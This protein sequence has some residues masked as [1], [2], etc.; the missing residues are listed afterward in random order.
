[1]TDDS[2]EANSLWSPRVASEYLEKE[3]GA[4]RKW[5][6]WLAHDRRKTKPLIPSTKFCGYSVLYQR[7]HIEAFARE[8]KQKLSEKQ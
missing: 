6:Q 4:L 2:F 8:L 3:V 5:D 1:M 7:S